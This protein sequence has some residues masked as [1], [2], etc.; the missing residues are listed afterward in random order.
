MTVMPAMRSFV[1]S[2]W[3]GHAPLRTVLWRDMLVA[4]TVLN[5]LTGLGALAIL[6]TGGDVLWAVLVHFAPL[7]LNLLL[8]IAVFRSPQSGLRARSMAAVWFAAM[9]VL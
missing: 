3:H 8:L 5:L 2:R 4:G 9:L 6:A 7:P 1:A